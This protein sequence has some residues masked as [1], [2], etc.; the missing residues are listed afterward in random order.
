MYCSHCGTP[1]SDNFCTN[2]GTRLAPALAQTPFDE[3]ARPVDWSREVRYDVL[4]AHPEVRDL[5]ARASG[6]NHW[7]V[8]AET[9]LKLY[10]KFLAKAVG[11]IELGELA[12]IVVPLFTRMG[13]RATKQRT[14]TI[15]APAGRTIVAV[16]CSLAARGNTIK[17]VHQ[18][19]DGCAIEA[20][21]P[22][23][24]WSWEGTL[25][26]TVVAAG[27][28]SHLE[29]RTTIGGQMYDWGKSE[30][31]LDF[32]VSDVQSFRARTSAA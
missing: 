20:V 7:N 16:L 1:G 30:R 2:C 5:L 6:G 19:R 26:V 10:D 32:L 14:A 8:S 25:L 4:V 11:G 27:D 15:A 18:A 9:C 17:D 21:L 28:R 29:A 23:D 24:V 12:T 22:S 31:R 3:P 13:V